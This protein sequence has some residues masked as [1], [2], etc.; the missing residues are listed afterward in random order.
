MRKIA[1]TQR[2]PGFHNCVKHRRNSTRIAGKLRRGP[3][4]RNL[5]AIPSKLFEL[6]TYA[7]PIVAGVSG[8]PKIFIEKNL[9]GTFTFEPC[10]PSGLVESILRAQKNKTKINRE[11]F[12]QNYS[13]K[14][15]NTKMSKSILNCLKH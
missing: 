3:P 13:R 4:K 6:S 2:N 9:S 10:C 15:I 8:F 12:I 7:K 5:P 1:R 14:N 11:V